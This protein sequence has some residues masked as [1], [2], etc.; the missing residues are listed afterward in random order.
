MSQRSVERVIGR[1]ATD[2]DFRR[3]FEQNREV[4]LAEIVAC[5]LELTPVEHRA[6][7]ELDFGACRRFARCLDPR[8]QKASL[9]RRNP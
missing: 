1:L 4:V 6:L 9:R 8:I 7:L 5:G 2:E 3:R